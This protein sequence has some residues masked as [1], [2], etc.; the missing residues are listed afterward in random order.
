MDNDDAAPRLQRLLKRA[1][2]YWLPEDGASF[3]ST[4]ESI[5]SALDTIAQYSF[6]L[7]DEPAYPA[8]IRL[9]KCRAEDND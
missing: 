7:K 1:Q 8:T 4:F 5:A 2:E 6:K 3:R 9:S